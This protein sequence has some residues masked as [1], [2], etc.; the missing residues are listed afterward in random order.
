MCL[1]LFAH[2]VH[3]RYRLVVA[4]NRD[5]WFRRPSA[6]A[7]FWSDRPEVLAGRDLEHGG[8]WL[9]LTR[10][11]RFAA[12]TN[13][14]DP[15][16]KRDGAPSRGGLVTGF[17]ASAE[18]PLAYAAQLVA[19][20]AT[21]NGFNLL[22]GSFDE[23]AYVSTRE[24]RAVQVAPGVHGLSNGVLDE[25]WPKVRRGREGLA[26]VVSGDFDTEDLF[27]L[28]KDHAL[29]PDADLPDT[30]VS[31]DWERL[32]SA[33]HIVADGY[34]TR[35]ATVVLVEHGGSATFC[36]RTFDPVGHAVGDVV[37]R[38]QI[39]GESGVRR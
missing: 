3:P 8:T 25:A 26:D 6:P 31:R 14:R 32:L 17:L 21:Y 36:E 39:S 10:A 24:R 9:G 28:L 15:R 20:A 35:C 19:A 22:A 1:I 18:A 7:G 13:F 29:A 16:N 37:H 11:G 5:E 27:A 34:G 33:M 23:L 2:G 12:L 38:F 30:G 4:A